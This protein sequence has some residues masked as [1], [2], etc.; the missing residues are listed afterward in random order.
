MPA[1]P[2]PHGFDIEPNWNKG[3]VARFPVGPLAPQLYEI[4]LATAAL[5][6]MGSLGAFG[7]LDIAVLDDV[8]FENGFE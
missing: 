6:P 5:T 4:D 2:L 3:F 1:G 8:I 7:V